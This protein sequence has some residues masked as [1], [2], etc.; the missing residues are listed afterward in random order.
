[1]KP[2]EA[3]TLSEHLLHEAAR[4][5]VYPQKVYRSKVNVA[6][7]KM[8]ETGIRR[9]LDWRRTF[10]PPE[11]DSPI[12]FFTSEVM[13]DQMYC[14]VLLQDVP[15]MVER[16]RALRSL[17]LAGIPNS[18]YFVY[19]REAAQCY[20]SGLPQAAI[21]LSRAAVENRLKE[22]CARR[23]GVSAVENKDLK[24]LIWV[25]KHKLWWTAHR[26]APSPSC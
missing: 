9:R 24:D 15:R 4:S 19:L 12:D 6:A 7:Q 26:P 13:L 2:A 20:V 3:P 11:R 5:F 14:R 18:E 22:V 25:F 16:T 10:V 21:A 17:T 1:M 23:F 8:L